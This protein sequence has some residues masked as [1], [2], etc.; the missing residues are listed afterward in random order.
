MIRRVVAL[1][2]VML[3]VA[4]L[5]CRRGD[6]KRLRVAFVSNN[7]ENFWKLAEVGCRKAE[8][9]LPVKVEFRMPN[10]QF[11]DQKKMLTD[12]IDK[13][14]QGIAVSVIDAK[15]GEPYIREINEKV[16]VICQDND[17]PDPKARR[18]YI[19]TDNYQAGR[20]AGQLVKEAIPKGGKVAIFVGDMSAQNAQ[21]RRQGVLDV[22]AGI[23]QERMGK[24]T[25][26]GDTNLPLGNGY[27]LL[28]TKTDSGKGEREATCQALAEDIFNDKQHEDLACVVGLWAYNPPALLRAKQKTKAKAVIVGFDEDPTT[29]DAIE[30]GEIYGTV[31]QDPVNFGYKS[32]K[33]LHGF[34]TKDD[35]FLKSQKVSADNRIFEPHRVFKNDGSDAEK[36]KVAEFHKEVRR[37]LKLDK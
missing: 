31:V 26:A 15:H 25:P 36:K 7:T 6:E 4:S 19:G 16:V 13:G 3:L 20:A 33:L 30:K 17:V 28:A 37:H 2:C 29:L 12:L 10:G 8:G 1:C 18:L 21:E 27:I 24:M 5:G 14:I 23:D 9:E 34:L 11:D 22:L 35:T 32:V